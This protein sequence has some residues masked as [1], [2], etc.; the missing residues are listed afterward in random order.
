MKNIRITA[1]LLLLMIV[2]L[3]TG[4]L[5]FVLLYHPIP[6]ITQTK[7]QLYTFSELNGGSIYTDDGKEIVIPDCAHD[8]FD[9]ASFSR[10][11]AKGDRFLVRVLSDELDH[12]K[13]KLVAFSV[14][15]TTN[16][17]LSMENTLKSLSAQNNL[18]YICLVLCT[19]L[20]LLS[21]LLVLFLR[22]NRFKTK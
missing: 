20:A 2:L 4:I 18:S 14:L 17:Y 5:G 11:I 8:F 6:E 1:S 21:F 10:E 19:A 22:T 15:T 16:E 13:S 3:V 12:N 9:S 7:L